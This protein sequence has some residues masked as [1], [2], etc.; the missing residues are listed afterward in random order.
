MDIRKFLKNILLRNRWS[1]FEIISQES[2]FDIRGHPDCLI[3]GRNCNRQAVF[4]IYEPTGQVKFSVRYH[5][6]R[7]LSRIP[8]VFG[9]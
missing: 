6:F 7:S 1:N 9:F 8:V 4:A 5:Q 2:G 3:F